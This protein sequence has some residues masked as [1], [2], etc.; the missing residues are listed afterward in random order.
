[1]TPAYVLAIGVPTQW[2]SGLAVSIK[3]VRSRAVARIGR[4]AVCVRRVQLVET[5]IAQAQ[6]SP[7]SADLAMSMQEISGFR[8]AVARWTGGGHDAEHG[9]P[10]GDTVP[11]NYATKFSPDLLSK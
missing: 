9:P 8:R 1:M 10:A 11:K 2:D 4:N 6:C 5:S 7:L 3:Q